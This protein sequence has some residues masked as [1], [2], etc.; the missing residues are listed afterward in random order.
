[1]NY[2]IVSV[3]LVITGIIIGLLVFFYP[4]SVMRFQVKFYEKINWR[5]EPISLQKEF[6]RT[7]Y[8]GL[9]LVVLCL[10]SSVYMIF[11]GK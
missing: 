1:M 10:L 11:F 7:R 6:D 9:Y 4:V 2:S 3:I 8:T 5:I